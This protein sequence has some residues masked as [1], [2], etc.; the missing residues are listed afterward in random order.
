M[1]NKQPGKVYVVDY[2]VGNLGSII[3]MF[4][5]I[6]VTAQLTQKPDDLLTAEKIILPGVGSFDYCMK[7]LTDRGFVS[8]L[9]EKVVNQ[10]TPML[11]ICVGAQMLSSRSEEGVS[12]GLG[13]IDAETKDMRRLMPEKENKKF[14]HIGWNYVDL[15]QKHPLLD[16]ILDPRFYFVHTYHIV[17]KHRENLLATCEYGLIT[18]TAAVTKDNIAG[19]QFHP[20]KSHKYGIQLFKNFSKWVPNHE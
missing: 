14:P 10:K 19:M 11:G 18:V 12:D 16:K 15:E 6:G 5:R 3:N 13:W 4:R 20:E 8:V 9:N 1:N 2:G 17:C 7:N